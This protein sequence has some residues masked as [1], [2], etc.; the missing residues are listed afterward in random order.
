MWISIGILIVVLF[1]FFFLKRCNN[2]V[3]I[4]RN[5]TYIHE[6]LHNEYDERF[7]N[8]DLLLTACGIINTLSYSFSLK[9]IKSII[10]R[11]K[12]GECFASNLQYCPINSKNVLFTLVHSGDL[13]LNFVMQLEI[14]IF[15]RDTSFNHA[16][17]VAAVISRTEKI[18]KAIADAKCSYANGKKQLW[19]SAVYNFMDS[20]TFE[21]IRNQIGITCP[22]ENLSKESKEYVESIFN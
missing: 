19:H 10:V 7:P 14:M 2:Y 11:A 1:V 17:I 5:L 16:D 21:E 18:E 12:N 15:L 6:I 13:F 4:A 22:K 20:V 9:D 8:E 3:L